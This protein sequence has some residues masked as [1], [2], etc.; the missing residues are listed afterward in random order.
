MRVGSFCREPFWSESVAVGDIDWIQKIA[1][2]LPSGQV[3]IIKKI[4]YEY[5][6]TLKKREF[7]RVSESMPSYVLSAGKHATSGLTIVLQKR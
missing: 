3:D 1:D 2:H 6:K 4:S 5:K 7:G